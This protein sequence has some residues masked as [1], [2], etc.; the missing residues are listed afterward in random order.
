MYDV[1]LFPS[2]LIRQYFEEKAFWL[3]IE[4]MQTGVLKT[5]K[6]KEENPLDFR[7]QNL[8]KETEEDRKFASELFRKQLSHSDAFQRKLQAGRR[9][10]KLT[11]L[12]E[13]M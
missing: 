12:P 13:W 2:E 1:S 9:T 8:H 11:G 4:L 7:I 5:I 6:V 3:D 10:G